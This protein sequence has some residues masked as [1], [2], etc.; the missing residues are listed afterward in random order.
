[1]MMSKA[2]KFFLINFLLLLIVAALGGL[3]HL[4]HPIYGRKVVTRFQKSPETLN[5]IKL[6]KKLYRLNSC[7]DCHG[8]NGMH[9]TTDY[10]PILNAQSEHYLYQQMLD[11]KNG[12][13][14]NSQSAIMQA[15]FIDLS[16]EELRAI[17]MYLSTAKDE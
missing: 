1:M 7:I 2:A 13:R 9:P 12:I 15:I 16:D 5:K 10:Y 4:Y 11:I 8:K 17:S 6:G 3:A 14:N